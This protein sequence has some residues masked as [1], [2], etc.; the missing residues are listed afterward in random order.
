MIVVGINN[1]LPRQQHMA[2]K[3]ADNDFNVIEAIHY[4]YYLI[5]TQYLM[6][7]IIKLLATRKIQFDTHSIVVTVMTLV[8]ISREKFC[9]CSSNT[10]SLELELESP[11]RSSLNWK[12]RSFF[13]GK[14]DAN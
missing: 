9:T 7:G 1:T 13:A 8:V 2:S 11:L 14:E 3:I 10:S 12:G 5:H 4:K 6:L